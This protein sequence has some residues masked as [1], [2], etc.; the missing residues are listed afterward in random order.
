MLN[1]DDDRVLAFR[2]AHSGSSVT[3]GFSERADVRAEDLEFTDGGA[4][5]RSLGVAYE[6]RAAGRHGVMNLLAALAVA[7]VFDIAPERVTPT[8]CA[9]SRRGPCQASGR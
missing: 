9:R 8:E 7:R 2:P 6:T 3:F 5:F 1:A 4:R